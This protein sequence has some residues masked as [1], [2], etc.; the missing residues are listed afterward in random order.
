MKK[1][2]Y[3]TLL[4]G[5]WFAGGF[6]IAKNHTFEDELWVQQ[7]Y[8]M[9]GDPNKTSIAL[10]VTAPEGHLYVIYDPNLNT[11]NVYYQTR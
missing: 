5:L 7:V 4:C 8:E 6:F 2:I 1:W 9:I 11:R 3:T 10:G